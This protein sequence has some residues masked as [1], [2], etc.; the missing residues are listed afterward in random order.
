MGRVAA[1]SY[2]KVVTLLGVHTIRLWTPDPKKSSPKH[3][4]GEIPPITCRNEVV[5][6]RFLGFFAQEIVSKPK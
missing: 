2:R 6:G 5:S 4:R 3:P 1:M